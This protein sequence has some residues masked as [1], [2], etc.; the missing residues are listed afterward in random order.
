M[1]HDHERAITNF[2]SELDLTGFPEHQPCED[3]AMDENLA[4]HIRELVGDRSLS[5]E[6][7]RNLIEDATELYKGIHDVSM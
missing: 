2:S 1:G 4:S 7:V 3:F 5:E 6:A